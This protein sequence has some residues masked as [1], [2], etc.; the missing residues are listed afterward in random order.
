MARK[1]ALADPRGGWAGSAMRERRPSTASC[2]TVFC[3]AAAN[4]S[5]LRTRSS[6]TSIVRLAIVSP[7]LFC[8]N[9]QEQCAKPTTSRE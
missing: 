1:S 9:R 2:C 5:K 3:C 6:G 4:P 7:S 8:R